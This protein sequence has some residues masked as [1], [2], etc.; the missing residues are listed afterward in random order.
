VQLF[1][2]KSTI[3]CGCCDQWPIDYVTPTLSSE[4]TTVDE[5]RKLIENICAM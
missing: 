1:D 4:K 3:R 5:V 2:L